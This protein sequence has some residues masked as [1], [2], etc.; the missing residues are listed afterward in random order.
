MTSKETKVSPPEWYA[1]ARS[2]RLQ[3]KIT[4]SAFSKA[5]KTL[6]SEDIKAAL[7]LSLEPSSR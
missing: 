1:S 6:I 2:I 3:K 7:C 4:I 5:K